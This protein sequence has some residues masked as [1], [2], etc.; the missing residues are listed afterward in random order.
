MFS[1]KR[2]GLILS[3]SELG[4]AKM[5]EEGRERQEGREGKAENRSDL[6]WIRQRHRSCWYRR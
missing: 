1:I 4:S 2:P 3:R 5:K 6:L